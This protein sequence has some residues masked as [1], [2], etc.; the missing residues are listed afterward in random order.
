MKLLCGR[1]MLLQLSI[2][3]HATL[4]EDEVKLFERRSLHNL[5]WLRP[6]CLNFCYNTATMCA[7]LRTASRSRCEETNIAASPRSRLGPTVL[8]YNHPAHLFPILQAPTTGK[9][10][11]QIS[12]SRSCKQPRCSLDSPR[13]P[14][15]SPALSPL[16]GASVSTFVVTIALACN[17][18]STVTVSS[19]G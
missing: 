7:S 4:Q 8:L 18:L 1:M 2:A 3:R 13:G 10:Q 17:V 19:C 5:D 14:P 11:Q 16:A 15:S 12:Y 9:Q 6:W